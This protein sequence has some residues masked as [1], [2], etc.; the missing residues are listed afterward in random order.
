MP[1]AQCQKIGEPWSAAGG[2]PGE[3]LYRIVPPQVVPT[4]RI[5]ALE[6]LPFVQPFLAVARV[7]DKRSAAWRVAVRSG[8]IGCCTAFIRTHTG[9]P[10]HQKK[11]N[12]LYREENLQ[13][14][15]RRP[16]KS[17]RK[18]EASAFPSKPGIRLSMTSVGVA[19]ACG[20]SGNRW[21]RSGPGP[22]NSDLDPRQAEKGP[23]RQWLGIHVPSL[24]AVDDEGRDP[25]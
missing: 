13:L 3:A 25:T 23:Y 6:P 24:E 12:R 2:Y 11:F 22:E 15:C 5:A 4:G 9:V 19:L 16:K 8:D 14:R 7:V 18:Q 1:S 20:E 21:R 10:M 17:V